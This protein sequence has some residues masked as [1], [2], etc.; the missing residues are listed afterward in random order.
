[1]KNLTNLL[2]QVGLFGGG[3][4]GHYYGNKLLD[5]KNDQV[6]AELQES[7][8]QILNDI[9][10]RTLKIGDRLSQLHDKV[11][12]DQKMMNL[13]NQKILKDHLDKIRDNVDNIKSV[14]E[15][16]NSLTP[17]QDAI[18]SH[19]DQIVKSGDSIEKIIN[20]VFSNKFIGENL[21][22]TIHNYLDTLTLLELSSLFN[23]VILMT[24]LLT[25]FSIL[26][27]FFG[28]ELIRYFD[29]EKKYPS[30][31]KILKVRSTLQRYYLM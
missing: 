14:I 26:S 29:L 9:N 23:S 18:K 21:I 6:E 12:I 30:L 11:N 20:D 31:S 8:D 2:R 3:V 22:T 1:M 28:N 27:I 25:S 15:N 17:V 10:E 7:R 19:R 4:L 13:E 16:T 24:L 5:S